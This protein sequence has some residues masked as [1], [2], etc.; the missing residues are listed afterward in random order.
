M[1][2]KNLEPTIICSLEEIPW[3]TYIDKWKSMAMRAGLRL[4][5]AEDI[6]QVTAVA[7]IRFLRKL[8]KLE[9]K[10]LVRASYFI[11]K[12]RII[13]F[14][15][16][17]KKKKLMEKEIVQ[18]VQEINYPTDSKLILEDIF[19]TLSSTEQKIIVLKSKGYTHKEISQIVGLKHSTVKNKY[20]RTK[21]QIRKKSRELAPQ[22]RK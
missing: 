11:C 18:I 14:L 15:R 22:N 4:D 20:C 13:D 19:K 21:Q 16:I 5:E 10:I 2:L 8:E 6:A 17:Q 3:E 9:T 12:Y 1:K 7:L